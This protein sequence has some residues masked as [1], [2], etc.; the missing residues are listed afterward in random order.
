MK[1]MYTIASPPGNHG[2][3]GRRIQREL[4]H[5]RTKR[6]LNAKFRQL[7]V[8]DPVPDP[9]A[10]NKASLII[11]EHCASNETGSIILESDKSPKNADITEEIDSK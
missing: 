9:V 1:Q 6:C 7:V 5:E 8:Q 11:D 3:L 10:A 2:I 4:E